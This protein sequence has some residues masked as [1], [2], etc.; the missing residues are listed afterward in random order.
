[1][2]TTYYSVGAFA[3][4]IVMYA[5]G[6]AFVEVV[7]L[8]NY[9]GDP[10]MS[11]DGSYKDINKQVWMAALMFIVAGVVTIRAKMDLSEYCVPPT[12]INETTSMISPFPKPYKIESGFPYMNH[13]ALQLSE[14]PI[15]HL[16]A[17][18]DK[19]DYLHTR[20][21]A[22]PDCHEYTVDEVFNYNYL[23]WVLAFF[24]GL[25]FT[26]LDNGILS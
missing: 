7:N 23:V 12:P 13:T 15:H 22:T 24:V 2:N 6:F 3:F 16:F 11:R 17:S 14:V 8:Q 20:L 25:Q 1:M 21:K 10:F 4:F 9:R 18:I 26:H 19:M 5:V